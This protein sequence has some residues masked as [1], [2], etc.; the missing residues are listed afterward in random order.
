MTTCL[1][2]LGPVRVSQIGAKA[3]EEDGAGLA[4]RFRSRRTVALLE[5]LRDVSRTIPVACA[6]PSSCRGG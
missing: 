4:P 6:S 2:L 3:D 1:N 5:L